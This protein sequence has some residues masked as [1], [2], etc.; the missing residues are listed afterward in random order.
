MSEAGSKENSHLDF[1]EEEEE[2]KPR[3]DL[4]Q[5]RRNIPIKTQIRQLENDISD[6][7]KSLNEN[8]KA[9]M[10]VKGELGTLEGTIKEKCNELSKCIIDD[11]TN[12]EKDLRR[13]IQNDRTE[14]DFFKVQ[15][16][17][18][19]DNKVKLQKEVIS[20]NSRMKSCEV[21]IGVESR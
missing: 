16:N 2:A 15:V 1:K 20:L 14:T 4:T 5:T 10:A 21:D 12:F 17:S 19:N 6:L 7:R 3:F 18:L 13:V 9:S 8:K 11:L